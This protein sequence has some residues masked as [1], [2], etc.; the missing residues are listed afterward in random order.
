MLTFVPSTNSD[1]VRK[2]R[3]SL[4]ADRDAVRIKIAVPSGSRPR[5]CYINV[6]DQIAKDGGRMQLGWAVWQHSDLFVEAEPHAVYDPG[7]GKPWVEW[8]K[9]PEWPAGCVSGCTVRATPLYLSD[10]M[11][12][13]FSTPQAGGKAFEE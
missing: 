7:D 11:K 3:A 13:G 6:Q 9:L 4:G 1:A 2:L 8:L 10:G 12:L 5:E